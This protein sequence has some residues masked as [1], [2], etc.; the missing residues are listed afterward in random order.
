MASHLQLMILI[1]ISSVVL[2]INFRRKLGAVDNMKIRL[3]KMALAVQTQSKYIR[4]L[5]RGTLNL[6][7][8]YRSKILIRDRT[9]VRC[10]DITDL[11]RKATSVDCRLHV[12]DDRRTSSDVS[13][14][15][16]VRN[17]D[18]RGLVLP[19]AIDDIDRQWKIGRRFVVWA[20][21]RERALDKIKQAYPTDKGFVVA[22]FDM[23]SR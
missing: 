18:Y 3:V 5:A 23:E 10:D 22:S 1:L 9:H 21:D 7:R 8:L 11:I 6:G 12:L 20:V 15:A 17:T 4:S 19:T 16:V 14:V 13:W 2:A